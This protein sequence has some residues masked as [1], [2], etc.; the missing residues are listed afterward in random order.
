MCRQ[1]CR[2][3]YAAT[4]DSHWFPF[5]K[6][7]NPPPFS[8]AQFTGQYRKS[9]SPCLKIVR[10]FEDRRDLYATYDI[11]RR[12]LTKRYQYCQW[13]ATYS[14][15]VISHEINQNVTSGK[16]ILTK[17]HIAV[18]SPLAAA[19][20]FVRPR[21]HLINGSLGSHES[22]PNGISIGSPFSR[23]CRSHERD[24][25]RHTQTDH[26]TPSVAIARILCN[27]CDAD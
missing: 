7:H 17:R 16:R 8:P 18:L 5:R 12:T 25:D 13:S 27:A 21:S 10:S 23:C 9:K 26:A 1:S 19:N 4:T 15:F 11:S 20:G 2:L 3:V 6:Q 24:T 14:S 22:A